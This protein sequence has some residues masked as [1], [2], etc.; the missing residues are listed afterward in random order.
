MRQGLVS[1]VI[2]AAC[3]QAALFDDVAASDEA[4]A[5]GKIVDDKAVDDLEEVRAAAAADP[6]ITG[7]QSPPVKAYLA[8]QRRR[9]ALR[10]TGLQKR[11]DE[12][13]GDASKQPLV[14][15]LKQQLADLETRPLEQV[16]FDSAYGYSP[17]TG[18]VGYSKKV[19][20]LENA[21]DGTSVILVDN[22][23]LRIEGLG[24]SEYPSGKF[25]RVDKAILIGDPRPEVTFQG[26]NRKSF[27]ATLVDLESLLEG[28]PEGER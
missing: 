20:L 5:E 3:G 11:I 19:R 18:L 4:A 28:D 13:Q 23:A 2:V 26:S 9:R 24:T 27:A 22:V 8:E 21:A 16:S 25:F 1:L 15:V 17:A 14:D 12:C 6:E 10:V 7:A